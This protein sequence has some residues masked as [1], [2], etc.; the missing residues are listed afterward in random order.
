MFSSLF[1]LFVYICMMDLTSMPTVPFI[2]LYYIESG[3]LKHADEYINI[4]SS[5][6]NIYT[7]YIHFFLSNEILILFHG[8]GSQEFGFPP[9]KKNIKKKQHFAS[10]FTSNII[11][12]E[13]KYIFKYYDDDTATGFF[14]QNSYSHQSLICPKKF[15]SVALHE[16]TCANSN[17]KTKK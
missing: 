2:I 15:L 9:E 5:N 7:I 6:V 17:R 10:S 4:S 1:C 16:K 14:F 3:I 8:R 11:H 13:R 12:D